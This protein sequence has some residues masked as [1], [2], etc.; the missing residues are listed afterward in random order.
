MELF[1]IFSYVIKNDHNN[2]GLQTM[3]SYNKYWHHYIPSTT[4]TAAVGNKCHNQS[5]ENIHH[6]LTPVDE[7]VA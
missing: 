7:K 3:Y 2:N 1:Q 5:K 4:C 6:G